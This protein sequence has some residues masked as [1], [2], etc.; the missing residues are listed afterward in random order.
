MSTSH[1]SRKTSPCSG[2]CNDEGSGQILP[3]HKAHVSVAQGPPTRGLVMS[4][5]TYS[6]AMLADLSR[7][8]SRSSRAAATSPLS[9]ALPAFLVA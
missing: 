7:P 3:Q 6:P 4:G 5:V 1:S 9:M 2:G 8:F